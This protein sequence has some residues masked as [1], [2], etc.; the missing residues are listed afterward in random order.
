LNNLHSFEMPACAVEN[1]L[2]LPAIGEYFLLSNEAS[3]PVAISTLGDAGLSERLFEMKPRGLSIVGKTETENIGIEKIVRNTLALTNLRYLIVCGEDCKGHLSGDALRAL[4]KN[5]VDEKMRIIG[6]EGK[7]PVLTNL[8]F[9]EVEAFRERIELVD[10]IGCTDKA[11]IGDLV[12]KLSENV[13]EG[14]STGRAEQDYAS[15]APTVETVDVTDMDPQKV[16]LDRYGY[17]VVVPKAEER[18]IY[19]E[20]YDYE[21]KLLRIIR[22]KDARNIYWEII[23]KGWI[24]EMSHAAYLGKELARAELSMSQGFKYVQD[25]G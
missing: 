1:T 18:L 22:G 7:Q 8:E 2:K 13:C 9:R 11:R 25:K 4:V 24:S 17:F 14:T 10:L 15:L 20:H 5:S 16:K 12:K 23:N 6:A 21:N 3:C 19:V